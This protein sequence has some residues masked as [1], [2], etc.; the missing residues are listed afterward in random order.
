MTPRELHQGVLKRAAQLL[1]QRA[2]E[3]AILFACAGTVAWLGGWLYLAANVVLITANAIYLL[4]RNPEIIV[5][6]G[7]GHQGTRGFDWV[8]LGFYT[9]GYLAMLVVAGLDV[10][11][12]WAPLAP[13]WAA[14]GLALMAA[15]MVPVAGAMAVNRNLEQTVRIQTDRGHRVATTG[16]YRW[17]RHPM[18]LG[19]L[20]AIPGS[21]LVLGSA[22][23]FVPAAAAVVSLVVRT[24]LE[25]RTLQRDLEGYAE[26]ATKTRFRL[27]PGV[28]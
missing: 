11:F 2:V 21:A 13:A 10:R 5:E 20:L 26:Y 27:V 19:M 14:L 15:G 22:W 1:V 9:A 12:G 4:P 16:P 23:T 7:K 25:D 3:G 28:W 18:Y 6:R 8:V 24:A 17:V